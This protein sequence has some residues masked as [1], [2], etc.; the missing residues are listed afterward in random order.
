MESVFN[1]SGLNT[2]SPYITLTDIPFFGAV[3]LA[4]LLSERGHAAALDRLA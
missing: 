1:R 2:F 4:L 3:M